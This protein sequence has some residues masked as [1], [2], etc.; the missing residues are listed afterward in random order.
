MTNSIGE[1][2]DM[3]VI[4]V[5]GSNTKETHPVIANRMIK[6]YRRGAKIIVADPRRVPMV[7]FA[8]V[9]LRLRPGAD[10]ALLNGMA[11]VILKEGLEDR[12]FIE[13][14]TEGFAQWAESIEHYSPERAEEITG[15]PREDIIKAA[16][17]YAGSERAGIFYTMGITQHSH[18]TA[19][20][21]SLANLALVTG[22]IGRP[23]TGVNPLRGQNNVR[24]PGRGH[25]RTGRDS[26]P[27]K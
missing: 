20:V 7:K 19:N 17:M 16:R 26:S 10:I 4:F 2:E 24:G 22:N 3:E 6:A 15:V 23:H 12:G 9:F 25:S 8:E 1:I 13:K 5:I 18:G 11:H 21:S 14:H 27:P